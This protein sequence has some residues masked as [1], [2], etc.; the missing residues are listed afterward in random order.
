MIDNYDSFTYNLVQ[1]LLSLGANVRTYRNDAI[2]VQQAEKLGP[3]HLVI[4]PGPGG[5]REAGV[6][7]KMIEHFAGGGKIPVLGVCLGH[8]A[9]A[10]VF[11]GTV[12][13]APRLMHGKSSMIT[14]DGKGVYAGLASPVEV[15]RYHSLT[16]MSDK[17]P[18]DFVVTSQTDQGEIMGI[19]HTSWPVE[20]VQFHP[21]SVLTPR[22]PEMVKNFLAFLS[23]EDGQASLS[24][25]KA[26]EPAAT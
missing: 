8:Q 22:G 26:A 16:I 23:G 24:E 21:E 19:R 12:G 11:G 6:S 13:R 15:G 18:R 5:P 3:T 1:L 17:L 25:P 20:G 9:M 2:T 4:S 7:M 14:H 10:E